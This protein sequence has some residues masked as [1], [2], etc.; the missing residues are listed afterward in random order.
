MKQ[1]AEYIQTVNELPEHVLET[2]VLLLDW[3]LLLSRNSRHL[4]LDVGPPERLH[5]SGQ[6][7]R[8]GGTVG[9]QN[10]L[11]FALHPIHFGHHPGRAGSI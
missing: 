11:D 7:I 8:L 6:I 5:V 4:V 9:R 1:A 10:F 3:H 2:S